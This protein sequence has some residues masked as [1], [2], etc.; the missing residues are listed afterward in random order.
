[1]SLPVAGF[2]RD[3]VR[4]YYIAAKHYP[5]LTLH[6]AGASLF[7][8][9]IATINTLVP[10]LMR[11]TVNALSRP[12]ATMSA[13][14]LAGAYGVCW[15]VAGALEWVKTMAA[16]AMLSRCDAAYNQA[17]HSHL[18]RTDYAIWLG[19]DPG[20]LLSRIGRSAAAFSALTH[21]IFWVVLPMV[22]QLC[23]AVGV[24]WRLLDPV[25]AVGLAIA[26][27]G[28]LVVTF[29][30]AQRT[31]AAHSE[32]FAANDL[33]HAHLAE[34]LGFIFDVKLNC[35]YAREERTMAKV[36]GEVVRRQTRANGRLSFQLAAQTLCTGAV[37]TT[38]LIL[39]VAR[40]TRGAATPGD[41]VMTTGYI[42]ALA[43]PF[44]MLAASLSDLRGNHLALYEGFELLALPLE[45]QT[46]AADFDFNH[47]T[48][49][50]VRDVTL[51]FRGR[52]ILTSASMVAGN[53]QMT[54][55][56][57]PSGAGKSSLVNLL[58]GL[59]RADQGTIRL[60]GRSLNGIPV[61]A[62]TRVL[63]VVP[64]TPLVI[65]GTLRD[66]LIFGCDEAPDDDEIRRIA[67]ELEL[68]DLVTGESGD[69]LGRTVGIQGREL[70]GGE[71]QRLALGR[72]L[73][74]HPRMLILDEPTSALDPQ[75]EQ[76]IIACARRRVP[77]MVV[78]TH[79]D[80]VLAGASRIYRLED[81]A[82]HLVSPGETKGS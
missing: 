14:L 55:L 71:R 40:V 57:G 30:L 28:L 46:G 32:L 10:Y 6:F 76:R 23:F 72:A 77:T 43:T 13:L 73:L 34:R 16:S 66:N 29:A 52:P 82:L 8:V 22:I 17:F 59:L 12:D 18:V 65:S 41:F 1:M 44:T 3:Y 63:A 81:G 42:L 53:G 4:G 47:P 20:V 69:F 80:A 26:I 45:A 49:C 5:R 7:V 68:E 48:A 36:L 75:R 54:A 78:V 39:A 70:S 74:R 31:R 21:T 51:A 61:A 27:V 62:V 33:L 60:F 25:Y 64:Q 58:L 37:L 35:A 19:L 56:V 24:L 9:V 2:M 15:S 11:E 79:R 50:E 67:T 38:M